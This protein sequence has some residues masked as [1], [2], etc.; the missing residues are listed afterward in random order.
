MVDD[1]WP[2]G[3]EPVPAAESHWIDGSLLAPAATVTAVT[4]ASAAEV[5]AAFGADPAEPTGLRELLEQHGIDPWVA[6]SPVAGGVLAVEVNGWQGAQPPVI[7]AASAG[8]RAASDYW[9]V[10]ALRTLSFARGAQVLASFEPGLQAH[11]CTDAE[12]LAALAGLSFD[13]HHTATASCA[14]AVARFTGLA[15]TAAD[16]DRIEAADVAYRILPQLPEQYPEER[17]ADGSRRWG[18]DGPLGAATDLL[19]TWPDDALRDLAWWAAAEA[20]SHSGLSD[21]PA[22]RASLAGRA[23]TGEAQRLARASG[24]DGALHHHQ[25]WSALYA[26]TNPDA[27][28]AAIRTLEHAGW[29]FGLDAAAFLDRARR[30][31]TG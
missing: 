23:L 22:A 9:N 2:S 24:L 29:A 26:A 14:I 16:V 30:R 10:N 8:G 15:I 5:L 25:A 1:E 28:A 12:V 7:R 11:D 3:A 4:G 31:V 6:V 21:E 27:L 19:A 20:A 17:L 13:D 18:G